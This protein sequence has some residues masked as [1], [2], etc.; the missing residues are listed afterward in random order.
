MGTLRQ[1]AHPDYRALILRRTFPELRELMDRALAV[2][3]QIG[4]EW[5]EQ[6]KRWRF[7][8]GAII[9]F[10]YCETYRDVLQYQGKQFAHIAF[11]E[12]GQ[13]AEER[14]WT[15]LMTRNRAGGPGLHIA[16]RGSAN[17]GGA[18]HY[19]LKRRFVDV[20]RPD[21]TPIVG[22]MGQTRAFVRA[23][24]RDN[25]TLLQNDP[26]YENRLKN[27]PE[28]EYRWLALGDW[29]AGGGLAFP[30]LGD[31]DTYFV[32]PS[33]VPEHWKVFG[34]FDWGYSH[35][36]AFGVFA[37]D[38][39]GNLYL[40]DSCHGR[41]LQ[42][43][44]IAQRWKRT[45]EAHNLLGRCRV[46]IAGHDCWAD[47]K[48]R[49]EHV[50]TLAEQ[51]YSE[52]FVLKR[53]NISRVAGVQNMRAYFAPTGP[54][55]TGVPRFRVFDT[56]G[57]RR[58]YEVLE[59]RIADP[60][61]VEDVLKTDADELGIGG[62]DPYDMIRYGLASRPLRGKLLAFASHD[63]PGHDP[64]IIFRELKTIDG[65]APRWI[66]PESEGHDSPFSD[67]AGFA[68]QLPANI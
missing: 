34:A 60:D 64:A 20:C 9:E 29:N 61:D 66:G 4:G 27:L 26:E 28:L 30:E 46:V 36:F 68:S 12:I 6:A 59:S 32:K 56:L 62:D 58:T 48:A 54:E 3:G 24:I 67:V 23:T 53:A 37:C 50:P 39:D 15:Y 42:P 31:H 16:M 19:W 43:P 33:R 21:G 8:S 47:V 49:S 11:D 22:S 51:F 14:I 55:R 10:G 18:G 41:Q 25:P 44:D 35:P 17:P 45:L 40:V 13:C 5:N 1:I 57:N 38:E 7:G 65:K 63:A 52:G 2:F